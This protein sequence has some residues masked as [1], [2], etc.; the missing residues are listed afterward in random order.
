MSYILIYQMLNLNHCSDQLLSLLL[1]SIS[2]ILRGVLPRV[3][4]HVPSHVGGF[5]TSAL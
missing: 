2:Y 4:Q 5:K 3:R 1:S